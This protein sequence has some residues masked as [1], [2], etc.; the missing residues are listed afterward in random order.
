MPRLAGG[1]E[2]QSGHAEIRDR[3]KMRHILLERK[4]Y[5]HPRL[6]RQ[7]FHRRLWEQSRL[8]EA[9]EIDRINAFSS[10]CW[11]CPAE[12]KAVKDIILSTDK[13]GTDNRLD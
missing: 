1:A 3:H 6:R 11:T 10:Q 12:G 9:K 4:G 8:Q 7:K 2:P 5:I 13:I